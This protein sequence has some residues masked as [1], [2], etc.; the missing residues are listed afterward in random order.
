MKISKALDLYQDRAWALHPAKL[1]EINH[2]IQQKTAG[3]ISQDDIEAVTEKAKPAEHISY[4]LVDG[5]AVI[6]VNGVI[7]K[8][9]NLFTSFSGGTSAELLKKDIAKALK[10][11]DV[12]AIVLDVESPGGSVDG[13][14][15]LADYIYSQRG[16]KPMIAYA[17]GLM[18]S[19]A[20][21]IGSATDAIMVNDTAEVGSIGV[22][23]THYDYSEADKKEGIKRTVIYAGKYKRI[24][25]DEKPLDAEGKEYLQGFVDQIYTIFVEA[26]ARQ[27]G[28]SIDAV[29]EN[30]AD[31]KLFIGSAAIA[32]GLADYRGTLTDAILM[33]KH[34]GES[35]MDAITFKEQFSAV[36]Q[37]VF[38]LGAAS[39]DAAAAKIA[40]A[41]DERSRVLAIL[42]TDADI[43]AKLQAIEEGLT[44]DAA[45]KVFFEAEKKRKDDALKALESAAPPAAGSIETVA[46]PKKEQVLSVDEQARK[47]FSENPELKKEF[48]DVETYVAFAR[49][50][51]RGLVK[52]K[53]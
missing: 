25:S 20:Y 35:I 1:E 6:P 18:A 2:F 52:V 22:A 48:G 44:L 47:D 8:K 19:A 49:A 16:K 34:A 21:W 41:A 12:M 24:A 10:D 43:S 28:A 26:V 46:V 27:R 33:V 9:M 45:Y 53:S 14:K 5:V 3:K 39:I 38:D 29:L 13:T 17:N 11:Q 50:N 40:G 42:K 36:Y 4:E 7:A 32:A 30:M 37:E 51:K 31:G 23:M 15:E